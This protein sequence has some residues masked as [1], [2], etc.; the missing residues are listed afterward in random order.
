[1]PDDTFYDLEDIYDTKIAP[2]MTQIIALCKEH[3]LSMIAS[4]AY[5]HDAEGYDYCTTY[6]PLR[7]V[8]RYREM[9][10]ALGVN[11]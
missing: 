1:M 3:Q 2:I 9:Y 4:F 6:L 8:P 11:S 10:L 7:N 5:R